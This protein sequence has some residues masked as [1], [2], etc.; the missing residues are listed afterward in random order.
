MDVMNYVNNINL[1][2][3]RSGFYQNEIEN[4][5]LKMRITQELI[6]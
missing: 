1:I 2:K 4:N 3:T 6:V 5:R